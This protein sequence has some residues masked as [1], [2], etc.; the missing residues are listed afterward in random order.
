MGI[1]NKKQANFDV[2][3]VLFPGTLFYD[4]GRK[5]LLLKSG[6]KQHYMM[7]AEIDDILITCGQQKVSKKNLGSALAGAAV[8]GIGG[9]L[10]AGSHEVEYI[11]NLTITFVLKDGKRVVLPLTIGKTKAGNWLQ[12]AEKIVGRVEALMNE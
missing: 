8:F 1:F 9:I 2:S 4:E 7:V 6:L 12:T 10:L 3:E 11:S 5:Q